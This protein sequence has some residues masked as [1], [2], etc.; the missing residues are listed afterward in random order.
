ML[1]DNF[2]IFSKLQTTQHSTNYLSQLG[3][4]RGHGVVLLLYL[5]T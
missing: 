5:Q 1:G 2:V 4:V 3:V